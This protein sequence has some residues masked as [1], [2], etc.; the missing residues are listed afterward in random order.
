MTRRFFF[1]VVVLVI[2]GGTA[3]LGV[4]Q[5]SPED[6]AKHHPGAGGPPANAGPGM[7]GKAGGMGAGGIG[8]MMGEGEMGGMMGGRPPAR[9]PFPEMMNTRELD[10]DA[11]ARLKAAGDERVRDGTAIIA[12]G[13]DR[14]AGAAEVEDWAGMQ[15]ALA[16]IREGTARMESGIAARRVAA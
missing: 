14:L 10:A 3:G 9:E 16:R 13:L 7:A 5:V 12:D 2:T 15:A 1:P 8:G 11:R 6:H 4:A